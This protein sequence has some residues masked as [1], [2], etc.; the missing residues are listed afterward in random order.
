[1]AWDFG[2]EIHV[3]TSYDADDTTAYSASDGTGAISEETLKAHVDQWLSDG[4]QEIASMLSPELQEECVIFS[5][6]ANANGFNMA[7]AIKVT[8]VTRSEGTAYQICR[9]VPVALSSRVS[10]SGDIVYA[11]AADPVYFIEHSN[12]EDRNELYIKPD[13]SASSGSG[14]GKI[15]Y[16]PEYTI[17]ATDSSIGKFPQ[18]AEPIVV[19]YAAIKALCYKMAEMHTL[20]PAHSDQD[21]TYTA[22]DSDGGNQGWEQVRHWIDNEEDSELAGAEVQALGAEVQ[23]WVA[24]YQWYQGKHQMLQQEYQQK[25]SLLSGKPLAPSSPPP[26]AQQGAR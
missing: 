4:A 19:L 12:S 6:Q 13:P 1:M 16:I 24:E 25:L 26:Q 23:Q 3:L 5:S 22:P 17:V 21:G 15:Y 7:D 2:A 14:H 9:K 18:I 20:V 8:G 10:D 11:T